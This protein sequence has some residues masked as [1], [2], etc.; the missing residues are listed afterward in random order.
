MFPC[1]LCSILELTCTDT[2]ASITYNPVLP[3]TDFGTINAYPDVPDIDMVP[4]HPS[5]APVVANH[6]IQLLVC[7]HLR[8]PVHALISSRRRP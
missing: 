4:F 8:S 6:V 7:P 2:T 3:V 1:D 5:P